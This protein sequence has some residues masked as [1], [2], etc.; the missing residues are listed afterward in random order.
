[1]LTFGEA[2]QRAG[3]SRQRLNRAIHTGRLPAERGGGPG[4][5]TRIKFEDLQAWCASEGLPMP[6]EL[7][8]RPER[9]RDPHAAIAR[10]AQPDMAALMERLERT[11]QQ[12]ID[13]AVDRVVERLAARLA[14]ELPERLGR[15]ERMERSRRAERSTPAIPEQKAAL[16]KQLR[17]MQAEGLSLQAMA[18]RL[19]AEGVPTLSGKGCWQKGTIG[20]LLAQ[21]EEL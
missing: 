3:V 10:T 2:V 7:A 4:K 8:E 13:G 5:P 1:M 12:A 15:T 11:I 19:T 16:L 20:N 18:N 17:A 6:V 9:S 14:A 21:A